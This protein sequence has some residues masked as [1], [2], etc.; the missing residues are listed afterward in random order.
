MKLTQGIYDRMETTSQRIIK[1]YG[2][3]GGI[4]IMDCIKLLADPEVKRHPEFVA[5]L[6]EMYQKIGRMN[7]QQQRKGKKQ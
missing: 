4:S 1:R 3:G 7:I 5:A 6:E 2:N